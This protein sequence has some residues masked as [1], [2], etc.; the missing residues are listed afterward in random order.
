MKC[1]ATNVNLIVLANAMKMFTFLRNIWNTRTT[2]IILKVK[3]FLQTIINQILANAS[4]MTIT[5]TLL[6][7]WESEFLSES[8]NLQA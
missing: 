7:A 8:L 3:N 6:E 5:F 4:T 2:L 1:T